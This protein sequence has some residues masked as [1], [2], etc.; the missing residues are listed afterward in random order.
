ME[1][2]VGNENHLSAVPIKPKLMYLVV[3]CVLKPL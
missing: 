2:L 1:I 3:P